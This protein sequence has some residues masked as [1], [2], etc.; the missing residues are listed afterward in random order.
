MSSF[1]QLL[2]QIDAFIRKYYKNELLKG[3]ILVIGVF[4]LSFLA[5]VSLEY[6]GRFNSIIRAFS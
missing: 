6:F 5:V 4:L 2:N 3:L 1:D